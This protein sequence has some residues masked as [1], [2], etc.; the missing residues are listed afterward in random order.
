MSVII[1]PLLFSANAHSAPTL[2]VCN[3][4]RCKQ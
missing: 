1:D 2:F 3:S 4:E